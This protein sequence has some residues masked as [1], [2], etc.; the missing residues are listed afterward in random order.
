MLAITKEKLLLPSGETATQDGSTQAR[1][2]LTVK[3][4]TLRKLAFDCTTN[5][6]K[7][8]NAISI[9]QSSSANYTVV[10]IFKSNTKQGLKYC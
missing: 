7:P 3:K 10:R 8:L 4:L 1:N 2:H 6:A 5:K 9:Q